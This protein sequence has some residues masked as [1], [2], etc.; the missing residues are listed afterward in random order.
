MH[1]RCEARAAVCNDSVAETRAF[2]TTVRTRR[3]AGSTCTK[4]L[5]WTGANDSTRGGVAGA[6]SFVGRRMN[7]METGCET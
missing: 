7:A 2:R 6:R 4:R 3:R 5:E 1:P